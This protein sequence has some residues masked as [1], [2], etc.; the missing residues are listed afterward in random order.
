MAN[1]FSPFSGPI[2]DSAGILQVEDGETATHDQIVN[3]DWLVE[4]VLG[5]LPV[6][7]DFRNMS[8]LFTGKMG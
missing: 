7:G 3:M 6:I 4:G 8:D 1:I 5:E 2:Y